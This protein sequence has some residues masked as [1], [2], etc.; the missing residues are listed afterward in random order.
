M[1]G[2]GRHRHARPASADDLL[3]QLGQLTARVR[4][5]V[6]VQRARVELA[7]ALQRGM[8]PS[9]LPTA[10]GLRVAARYAPAR[11]GLDIG[12]DWY[13]GFLL[14]DGTLSFSVG[15]VQGHDVEA[16]A[17]MGQV[18][19]ALRAVAAMGSTDP[20]EILH[21]ANE[22]LAAIDNPLFATCVFLRFDPR[23]WSVHTARAGHTGAVW[24][25]AD[26]VS[27]IIDHTPEEIGLPLAVL[28]GQTYT[29]TEYRFTQP[30]ALALLTDGVVEGPRFPLEQGLDQVARV[31]RDG[32]REDPEVLADRVMEVA[33]QTGHT[34]DAAV[35][36]LSYD[37]P[38]AC[39]TDRAAPGVV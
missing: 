17:Y 2:R 25:R 32:V 14:S 35:L 18:R 34:D 19:I 10:P 8:L 23:T 28:E 38:E 11:N 1:E 16:A 39:Q 5:E 12:G 30:G 27:G 33:E 7:E 36:V 6:E 15:D 22:L 4:E 31:L 26:G 24:A 3:S 37:G 29:V 13:D 9:T 20:G 21:T